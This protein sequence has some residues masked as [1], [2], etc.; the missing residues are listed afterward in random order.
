MRPANAARKSPL[1]IDSAGQTT[2]LR[3][4][5]QAALG[6]LAFRLLLAMSAASR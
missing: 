1:R 5:E 3:A 4:N 2:V 6:L